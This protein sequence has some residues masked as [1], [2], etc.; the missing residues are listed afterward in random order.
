MDK[1]EPIKGPRVEP[2]DV[3]CSKDTKEGVMDRAPLPRRW[4]LLMFINV[5]EMVLR[6]CYKQ[7]YINKYA[8]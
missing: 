3:Y 8:Y 4:C 5:H 6:E 7:K 2:Q 1:C